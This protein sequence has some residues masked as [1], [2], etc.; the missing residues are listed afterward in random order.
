MCIRD[1]GI[2][3]GI[4]ALQLVVLDMERN[5]TSNSALQIMYQT[6]KLLCILVCSIESLQALRVMDSY[7]D[8]SMAL[9]LLFPRSCELLHPEARVKDTIPAELTRESIWSALRD[10]LCKVK[11]TESMNRE[12]EPGDSVSVEHDLTHIHLFTLFL[13]SFLLMRKAVMELSLIHISEP[14][15]RLSRSRMPSS[16]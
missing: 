3:W 2:A 8:V 16:A 11:A 9:L 15:R 4:R 12:E 6:L 14:T 1:S 7:A 5:V 13:E 10:V